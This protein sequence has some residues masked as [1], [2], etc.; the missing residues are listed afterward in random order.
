M[1]LCCEAHYFMDHM[2]SVLV[3]QQVAYFMRLSEQGGTSL[4]S[5][6]ARYDAALDKLEIARAAVALEARMP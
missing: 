1:T 3:A 2:D 6:N 5:P 4:S